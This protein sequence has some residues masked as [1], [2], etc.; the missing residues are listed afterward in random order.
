MSSGPSVAVVGGT[1]FV[2]RNISDAFVTDF[3]TSFSRVR[4]L[5]RD[6][7]TPKAQGLA[8][9]G[10]ELFQ[11]NE[12][13]VHNSLDEAFADID[14]IVN[15]LPSTVSDRVNYAVLQAVARS[16]AKVYFLSEFEAD[17]RHLNFPGIENIE[18]LRRQAL[19]R[20]VRRSFRGKVIAL[21]TSLFFE[22][23]MAHPVPRVSFTS[24]RDIGRAVARLAILS[25]NTDSACVPDD[26]RI[27]GGTVT[28]EDVR[29]IVAR[30]RGLPPARIR[31]E[32]LR[33]RRRMLRMP[34]V[35]FP[36]FGGDGGGK[37]DLE[38]A[39][40]NELVN[41]GGT[42]WKWR[43]VEDY[44]RGSRNGCPPP[45]PELVSQASA[46]YLTNRRL[47]MTIKPADNARIAPEARTGT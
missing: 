22:L 7:T 28:F 36:E 32:D 16:R 30:V 43:S 18:W 26:V 11:V 34:G 44:V 37:L 1:G 19:A 15:T 39:N 17:H 2:G 6:A 10:A 14:V 29:D 3:R 45:P 27:A 46:S 42:M 35:P 13:D 33:E 38:A 12:D 4:I 41:P 20:E 25:T 5:T 9:E 21:Y 24:L 47:A 23:A 8:Y 31:T 40:D